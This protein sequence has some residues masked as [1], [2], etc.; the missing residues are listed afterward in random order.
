MKN[1]RVISTVFAILVLVQLACG[2]PVV[3][4]AKAGIAQRDELVRLYQV[5]S[6]EASNFQLAVDSEYAKIQ[7]ATTQTKDY[8]NAVENSGEVW[9]GNF[10][11]ESEAMTALLEKYNQQFGEI[12]ADQLDLSKLEEQGMLPN[13]LG[14]DF[15]LYVNS[16][17]QAPPPVP[18]S[19]VTLQLMA[20]TNESMETI[21]AAGVYWNASVTNYNAYRGK[22]SSEVV[23]AASEVLGFP[24]PGLLPF[25]KG[26]H[27]GPVTNPIG[28]P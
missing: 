22:V 18:D 23:A 16:V 2:Q 12:P 11:E 8:Y 25:Y 17:V 9:T 20:T 27:T 14:N 15:A 13:Q 21:R 10:R 5:A 1:I 28:T 26:G 3:D 4:V 19:A 6:G 7:A 24:L